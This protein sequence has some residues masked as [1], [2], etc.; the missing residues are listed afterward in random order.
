MCHRWTI[1]LLSSFFSFFFFACYRHW[2]HQI[3]ILCCQ[4]YHHAECFKR[5]RDGI[6]HKPIYFVKFSGEKY[7][8]DR[9]WEVIFTEK[10]TNIVLVFKK[11]ITGN[12]S[13]LQLNVR[14]LKIRLVHMPHPNVCLYSISFLLK[15]LF[16]LSHF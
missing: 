3:G 15:M 7:H 9:I 16:I 11:V 4:R 12:S 8:V 14:S 13:P 2:K 1:N 10:F 6:N 5:I